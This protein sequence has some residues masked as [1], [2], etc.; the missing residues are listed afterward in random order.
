MAVRFLLFVY[1]RTHA[2]TDA[3]LAHAHVIAR[4][5]GNTTRYVDEPLAHVRDRGH[6]TR[7]R[8]RTHTHTNTHTQYTLAHHQLCGRAAD[9]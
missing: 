9:D 1:T 4:A 5:L 6:Y 7:A 2:H 3:S 8:D